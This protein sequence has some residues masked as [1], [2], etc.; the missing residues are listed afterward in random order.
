MQHNFLK[1]GLF[2]FVMLVL[3][4]NLGCSRGNPSGGSPAEETKTMPIPSDG[5]DDI[6][7][8]NADEPVTL[9]AGARAQRDLAYGPDPAHRMDVYLPKVPQNAPVLFMVHGGAWM[10]GDKAASGVVSNKISY[11][12][13]KGYILVSVNYRLSPPE[14]LQQAEDVAKALAFAQSQAR[15]WGADEAR[16]VVV[17][18]SSGA[19][20]VSLLAS[21]PSIAL[22]QGA[23][24]WL[25]TVA[26]D[27][28]AFDVGKIMG[29]RHFAFYDRVFRD[30]PSYWRNASPIHRLKTA[31]K[32]M[33]A[34]CSS[35]RRISCP[36]AQSFV[37]KVI[38]LGGQAKVVP[39]A[40][41]H[42]AINHDLGLPGPYTEAVDA[43]MRSLGLP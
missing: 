5:L 17:G 33:L 40:K 30:D 20:L 18:H 14:P 21:D 37:D 36:Q 24:P 32:P 29:T 13:P 42:A 28:A 31:P 19:H 10:Y 16:F 2:V 23:K 8:S 6:D 39:I 27:S 15:L 22:G 1:G 35:E 12:L 11:W 41:S 9:P 3:A 25:G 38:A 43:F 26:L 7:E 4:D 34:V